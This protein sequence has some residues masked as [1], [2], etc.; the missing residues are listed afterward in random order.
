MESQKIK[1]KDIKAALGV[2]DAQL[3]KFRLATKTL[4]ADIIEKIGR[5]PKIGRPRWLELAGLLNNEADKKTVLKTL[6]ADKVSGLPSDDKFMMALSSFDDSKLEKSDK[7]SSRKLPLGA[8]GNATFTNSGIK[9]SVEQRY[10]IE[11]EI[12]FGN[13]ID[14]IIEKFMK[15]VEGRK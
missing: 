8:I 4:G 14:G 11:F 5:A 1:P 7:Q 6:S 9:L 2:D 10:A 12:F 13:E 3:S 15:S